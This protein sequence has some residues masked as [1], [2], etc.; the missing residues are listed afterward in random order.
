VLRDKKLAIIGGGNMA[1]AILKGLLRAGLIT[2]HAVIISDIVK[3]RL[4]YLQMTYDIK[5][6]SDNQAAATQGNI[7]ILAVKPQNIL[8]V[9]EEIKPL[10]DGSKLL[11][12]IAAGI[13]LDIIESNLLSGVRAIR[14]MP[15]APALVLEG[16]TAIA[17][18]KQATSEDCEVVKQIF[19]AVGKTYMVKEELMD[20][21]TGLS[22]SGPAYIFIIIEALADGGVKE[23]LPR[24]I[25]LNLAN[26]T[27]LGAAKM[28][29]ESGE[30]P[31]KLKDMIASPG[32]TTIA[33]LYQLELGG[34][35]AALIN[36]VSAA[37]ERSKELGYKIMRRD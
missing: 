25:A 11:I 12:S 15:N 19:S 8:E 31:G 27:V 21:V 29:W 10:V 37:T 14:V 20:V 7:I 24:D 3:D 13:S 35:R 1:E 36:A 28:L 30:H 2:P 9:M 34:I 18:G 32:G 22:G 5:V 23:G 4:R 16:A 26:Q 17:P 33:G 6:T